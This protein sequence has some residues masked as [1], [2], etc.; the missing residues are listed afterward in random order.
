[1]SEEKAPR[2]IAG[3]VGTDNRID[4]DDGHYWVRLAT[5]EAIRAEGFA[6][7]NCL[8]RGFYVRCAFSAGPLESGLWSLRNPSGGSVALAELSAEY[9]D[10]CLVQFRG[11]QNAMASAFAYRQLHDLAGFFAGEGR[12]LSFK[13]RLSEP[14][15]VANGRTFRWDRVPKDHRLPDHEERL[16]ARRRAHEEAKRRREAAD[17]MRENQPPI[18]LDTPFRGITENMLV[19]DEVEPEPFEAGMTQRFATAFAERLREGLGVPV[20]ADLPRS[21]VQ[22]ITGV[23]Q[24]DGSIVV[25]L[26]SGTEF[27]LPAQPELEALGEA[28][29]SGVVPAD[30]VSHAYRND[31]EF[32]AGIFR[33]ALRRARQHAY[34][35]RP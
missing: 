25:T 13:Y 31:P 26:S 2:P 30:V 12:T 23:T 8:A 28:V 15:L 7:R 18:P 32:R 16:E 19:L 6:M 10:M 33:A 4:C 27:H 20:Y 14:A 1:M 17:R 35:R 3:D 29:D 5:R 21:E 24:Q 22:T 11:P 9:D 34:G